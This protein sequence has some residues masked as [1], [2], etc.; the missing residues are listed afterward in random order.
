M[1]IG[2]QEMLCIGKVELGIAGGCGVV[3][4]AVKADAG[5]VPEASTFNAAIFRAIAKDDVATADDARVAI[6]VVEGIGV[7]GVEDVIG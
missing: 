5:E 2:L 7:A 3:P 4:G 6:G 1:K